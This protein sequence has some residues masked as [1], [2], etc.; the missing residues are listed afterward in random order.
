MLDKTHIL[1]KDANT[2]ITMDLKYKFYEASV[3][4]VG[5]DI[6]FIDEEFKRFYN[7]KAMTLR[8]DFC[9]TGAL[10]CEWVK[11]AKKRQA[12]GV[13]LDVEPMKQGQKTHYKKLNEDQ[14]KRMKYIEGDV[15]DKREFNTDIVCAFNFSY[16]ILHK[17]ADLLK[18][19][20]RVRKSLNKEGILY[21][22]LFG[23]SECYAPICEETEYD[24]HTY[25]WDLDRVDAIKNI[26]D[27]YIHFKDH[28]T[29]IKY[30][31]VFYYPF[32][33]YSIPELVEVLEEAG[34]ETVKTYWEKEDE[35]G[36][37]S[38][39]FYLSK[40]EENCDAWVTY[41]LAFNNKV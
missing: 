39:E 22:D 10:S 11:T 5:A 34:F 15:L 36:E 7:K 1:K 30:D 17:R 21:L 18:Y 31:K 32:R 38:G 23:G 41:I 2:E 24:D 16:L 20:K 40:S 6:D 9:G 37:G 3:Q 35:D 13:D 12:F 29:G 25:Y 8:E 27:Y 33:M 4:N 28:K 19:F 14:K 26:C